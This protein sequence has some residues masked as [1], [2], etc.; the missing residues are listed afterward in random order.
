MMEFNPP[1]PEEPVDD[2]FKRQVTM[3]STESP[4]K[5]MNTIQVIDKANQKKSFW[6][7]A[8]MQRIFPKV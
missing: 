8:Y 5:S 6:N 3:N 4:L 1:I 7:S 2:N